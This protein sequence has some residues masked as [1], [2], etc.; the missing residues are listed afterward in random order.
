[1]NLCHF[2]WVVHHFLKD[3]QISSEWRWQE[4]VGFINY[5][6][7]AEKSDDST[8]VLLMWS[9][10]FGTSSWDKPIIVRGKI[11]ATSRE[12][13]PD[14]WWTVREILPKSSW[15]RFRIYRNL[16]RLFM[17]FHLMRLILYLQPRQLDRHSF[18][19]WPFPPY[20]SVDHRHRLSLDRGN[21]ASWLSTKEV[22]R[23]QKGEEK[24]GIF[25]DD[26]HHR[27]LRGFAMF[28][29]ILIIRGT[30]ISPPDFAIF[31]RWFS[32]LPKVWVVS[33]FLE[34]GTLSIE[35]LFGVLPRW[36]C[37]FLWFTMRLSLGSPNTSPWD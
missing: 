30:N 25:G 32:Q 13:T 20:F 29:E 2:F 35:F 5:R 26:F 31:C 9:L 17:E 36:F 34:G 21:S 19:C 3:T 23:W 4:S 14:S 22:Q 6:K 1:M 33:V 18:A 16:P 7:V 12:V 8:M 24:D 10:K 15:F 37:C 28:Q 11:I 27:K